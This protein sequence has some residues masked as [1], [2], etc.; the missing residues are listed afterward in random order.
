M[1]KRKITDALATL[2]EAFATK[3][4]EDV[5]ALT[6]QLTLRQVAV[7]NLVCRT[8]VSVPREVAHCYKQTD[9]EEVKEVLN[10][11]AYKIDRMK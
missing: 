2:T 6:L 5:V 9:S 10:A 8:N 3:P 7:L 11:I 4:P 1:N